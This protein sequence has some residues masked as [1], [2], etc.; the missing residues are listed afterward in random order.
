MADLKPCPFCGGEATM[1]MST[2]NG[3]RMRPVY[4]KAVCTYDLRTFTSY[5]VRCSK[6]LT[7]TKTFKHK[8]RAF[9]AWNR[10][11]SNEAT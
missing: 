3:A 1:M 7:R 8:Q 11:A 6:C 2:D 10:R 5:C 9:T 4:G